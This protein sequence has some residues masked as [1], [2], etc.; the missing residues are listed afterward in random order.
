M[1]F[2]RHSEG[3]LFKTSMFPLGKLE[4]MGTSIETKAQNF[5]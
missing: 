4:I 1:T 2:L 5:V 3:N